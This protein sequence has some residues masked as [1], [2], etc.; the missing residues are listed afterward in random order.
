MYTNTQKI[1]YIMLGHN[2]ISCTDS[3]SHGTRG[4]VSDLQLQTRYVDNFHTCSCRRRLG[5]SPDPLHL[6][7]LCVLSVI[8]LMRRRGRKPYGVT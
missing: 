2:I 4:T 3:I 6:L 1:N 8:L 7:Q 5:Q